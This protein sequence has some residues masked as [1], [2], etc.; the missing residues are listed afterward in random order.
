MEEEDAADFFDGGSVLV[1]AV[2]FGDDFFGLSAFEV[3]TPVGD[4]AVAA[5]RCVAF[6]TVAD[7]RV[8]WDLDGDVGDGFEKRVGGGESGDA[9]ERAALGEIGGDVDEGRGDFGGDGE[10]FDKP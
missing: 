6:T 3:G 8:M 7:D 5:I 9:G 2:V 1:G 4:D 10:D